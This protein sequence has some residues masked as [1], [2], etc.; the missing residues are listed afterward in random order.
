MLQ[1]KI[2][3]V[4]FKYRDAVKEIEKIIE[5]LKTLNFPVSWEET[6]K[7]AA[8]NDPFIIKSL[9]LLSVEAK[10]IITRFKQT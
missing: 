9:D 5:K 1:N 7:L 2:K 3:V 6:V 4:G 8:T 10:N